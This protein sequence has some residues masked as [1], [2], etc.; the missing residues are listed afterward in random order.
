MQTSDEE[1]VSKIYEIENQLDKLLDEENF[2]EMLS[3]L[4]ERETLLKKLSQ[5]PTD[6]ANGILQSDQ[7]RAEKIK[8]LMIQT[9]DQ[10]KQAKYGEI[11]LRGY[12]SFY[13]Q[14]EKNKLDQHS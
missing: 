14:D 13:Q 6:L 3:L 9:S 2:E 8:H 7:M 11:G 10:A 4:E 5:I 12:K 1:L